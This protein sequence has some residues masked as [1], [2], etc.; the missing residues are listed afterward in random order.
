[1]Q[2]KEGRERMGWREGGRE[3]EKK[4]GREGGKKGGRE[5]WMEKREREER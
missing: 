3:G 5:E 1:M 2:K 4:G